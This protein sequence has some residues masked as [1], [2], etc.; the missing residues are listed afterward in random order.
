VQSKSSLSSVLPVGYAKIQNMNGAME[1]KKLYSE[2]RIAELRNRLEGIG[3]L[4]ALADLTIFGAG[5]YARL[6]ASEHSDIDTFFVYTSSRSAISNVRTKELGLF[7]ELIRVAEQMSFPAF[8]NDA[9]YLECLSCDDILMHLGSPEDDSRNFFTARML[10]LLESKPLANEEQYKLI[11]KRVCDAYYRDFPDH[12]KS[13]EP[14]FL[15]N[16]IGRFWNTMLVNYENRRNL[17]ADRSK[18]A[19]HKVKNFKLRFSRATTCFATVAAIG[20]HPSTLTIDD[21]VELVYETPQKRLDRVAAQRPETFE[22]IRTLR[23]DY[24]WFLE[25]TS[26]TTEELEEHFSDKTFAAEAFER[27]RAYGDVLFSVLS[28]LDIDQK[29]GQSRGLIRNLVI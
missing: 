27:A 16:D 11:V 13:F 19:K 2:T 20:A 7:G 24:E 28:T 25:K 9:Q 23:A 5:S 4:S 17:E 14:Q 3:Q 1:R 21:F 6:E 8:S 29:T 15:L 12:K 18:K 22:D 26:M 10:L